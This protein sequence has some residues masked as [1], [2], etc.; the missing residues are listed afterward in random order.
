VV[1]FRKAAKIAERRFIT[2]AKV[3][4]GTLGVTAFHGFF[5]TF[6]YTNYLRA[7]SAEAPL[8]L[9]VAVWVLLGI[10]SGII[11]NHLL[12]PKEKPEIG[13]VL[14]DAVSC[15]MVFL[16]VMFSFSSAITTNA[17]I[18][19][20]L[21]GG[22]LYIIPVAR[23]FSGMRVAMARHP[24][25]KRTPERALLHSILW[26]PAAVPVVGFL[27]IC[28]ALGP[29]LT[30]FLVNFLVFDFILFVGFAMIASAEDMGEASQAAEAAEA[31]ATSRVGEPAPEAP[32]PSTEPLS[33]KPKQPEPV[34]EFA[35]SKPPRPA[36]GGGL[37]PPGKLPPRKPARSADS[38]PAE[39]AKP[40][41]DGDE[42]THKAP[43]T[44]PVRVKAPAKPK[45]RF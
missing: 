19:L 34:V 25:L 22:L 14:T 23:S 44:P 40:R 2:S 18:I 15:S 42:P 26:I 30:L 29:D 6:L 41:R 38:K 5:A 9:T 20:S 33:S 4:A 28:G 12:T 43:N 36:A 21:L 39:P 7:E 1:L 35:A 27:H 13:G 45:K 32:A 3:L 31:D 37:K 16:C 11:L 8:S 24:E 10:A 17:A